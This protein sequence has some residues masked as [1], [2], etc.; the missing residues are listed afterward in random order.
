MFSRY[1][2]EVDAR[3]AQD[4]AYKST[5]SPLPPFWVKADR[6]A[7]GTTRDQS[8]GRL[9]LPTALR[10]VRFFRGPWLNTQEKPWCWATLLT[11]NPQ[12]CICRSLRRLMPRT[13][14]NSS[15]CHELRRS[16]IVCREIA[17]EV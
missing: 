8:L 5:G 11:R 17:P 14:G 6:E 4:A 13:E 3:K 1:V 12:L 9:H 2:V 16:A 10:S 7:T 15:S